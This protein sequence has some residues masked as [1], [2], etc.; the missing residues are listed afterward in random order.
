[1]GLFWLSTVPITNGT[2]ATVFGV[3]HMSM[4]AGIVFFTHQLGS[5]AGGWMGGWLY[6]RTGS[7]DIA[8]GIAI[9]LSIVAAVLNWPITERTRAERRAAI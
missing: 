5:F 8:W 7:Y 6:D 3:K 9:G 4:L 2:V 1:M